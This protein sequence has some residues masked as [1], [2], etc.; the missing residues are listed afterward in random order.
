MLG[1][2]IKS[3]TSLD[4]AKG[5]LGKKITEGFEKRDA[6]KLD[7]RKA[8][9]DAAKV[10]AQFLAQMSHEIRTP[11][12]GIIGMTE[13]TLETQLN[14]EQQSYLELVRSSSNSLLTIINDVL[15]KRI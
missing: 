7:A 15:M 2:L 8:A 1:S 13:L 14:Q 4:I 10:K 12:N 9:E 3:A 6:A 11:L 5:D